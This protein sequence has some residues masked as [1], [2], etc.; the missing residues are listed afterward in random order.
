LIPSKYHD[1]LA[2]FDKLEKTT[3]LP[4][5]WS[6]D[7]LIDLEEGKKPSFGPIYS[8]PPGELETLRVYFNE[9][10]ANGFIRHSKSP[11]GASIFCL[12]K[13]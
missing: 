13:R 3:I 5:H 4:E 2:I 9:N 6:Y 1:N 12:K 11:I 7:F 10:L 8:L